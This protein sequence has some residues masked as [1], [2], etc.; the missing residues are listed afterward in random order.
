[1]PAALI[2]I[3]AADDQDRLKEGNHGHPM[4]MLKKKLKKNIAFH[5]GAKG[6]DS[7]QGECPVRDLEGDEQHEIE[8]IFT[9]LAHQSGYPK[10][11]GYPKATI[12][13]GAPLLLLLWPFAILP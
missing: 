8:P 1:V 2:Q 12:L 13:S 6:I 4:E 11:S 10:E 7:R 9:E 5:T 3:E